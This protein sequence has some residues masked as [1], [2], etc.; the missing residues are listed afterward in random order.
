MATYKH[1]F[2]IKTADA[3]PKN[4]IT[5]T[6]Y[7]TASTDADAELNTA[8]F[9]TMFKAWGSYYS[10]FVAQNNHE[11]K[12]YDMSDATPRVPVSITNWNLTSAPSNPPL[13]SELA[14]CL[15][16]QAPPASGQPQAR[17]RGRIFIGP[18]HTSTNDSGGRPVASMRVA[19]AAA[20]AACKTAVAAN[21]VGTWW[22][23]YSQIGGTA[24]PVTNGWIDNEFDTQRRREQ[25]Y[26][27]RTTWS[28]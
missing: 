11:V 12:L 28:A 23:A 1:Q 15:S 10:T 26:T 27:T 6:L 2:V 24:I 7:S 18:L 9:I 20:A 25:G 19:I 17:R 13:P 5:N 14:C 22:V 8:D 21:G 4:Y 3:V 16:F